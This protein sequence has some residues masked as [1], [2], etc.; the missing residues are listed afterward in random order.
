VVAASFDVVNAYDGSGD[1]EI[2]EW[3]EAASMVFDGWEL[4]N[5]P[6]RFW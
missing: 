5:D 3:S 4:L 1:A 2:P 6:W